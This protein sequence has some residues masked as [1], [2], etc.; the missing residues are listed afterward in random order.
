MP[1]KIAL[2]IG[3]SES[4][5]NIFLH[6]AAA[7]NVAAIQRV[8]QDPN[9]GAFDQVESLNQSKSR[10]NAKGDSKCICRMWCK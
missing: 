7:N 4:N 10:N 2:L 8:L 5:D 9:L 1:K 6:S 3:V